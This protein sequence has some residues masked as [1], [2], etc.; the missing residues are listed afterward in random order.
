VP[1]PPDHFYSPL[2]DPVELRRRREVLWPS[3]LHDPPGIDFRVD[4]QIELL[5]ALAPLARDVRFPRHPTP[6]EPASFYEPNGRFEGL[7]ARLLHTLLRHLEPCRLVEVGGGYST[8]LIA[9]VNRRHLGGRI[10]HGLIEPHPE[11]WMLDHPAI[12][13]VIVDR[14]EVSGLAPFAELEAGDVLFIDSSHVAKTGSDVHF[15][16]L[17]VLPRLPPGV[18]VH[19][20]DVFL[21]QD[22]PEEWVLGEERSWNEQYLVQAL[23]V[24]GGSC[25]VLLGSNYAVERFPD[26]VREVFGAIIGGGS[27]WM[28]RV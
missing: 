21:P 3:E 10:R 6:G 5:R 2:V 17:E 9:D 8:R 27:F 14:V 13:Q 16:Y 4:A 15:L 24:G 19:A 1:F 28:R 11:D 25:E 22:Y 20:H 18:V 12:S 26:V 7:D 23:L